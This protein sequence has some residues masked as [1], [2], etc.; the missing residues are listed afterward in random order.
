MAGVHTYKHDDTYVTLYAIDHSVGYGGRNRMDD[1]QLIQILV[2][3]Y[4]TATETIAK[5][6][7]PTW[8]TSRVLNSSGRVIDNLDVDGQCGPLTLAAI[9]AVQKSLAYWKGCTIDGRI[10][11]I[12]DGGR[13]HYDTGKVI[14]TINQFDP[15]QGKEVP[16][17]YMD[18]RFY[19]MYFLAALGRASPD[20][21]Q[22]NYGSDADYKKN[23]YGIS[24]WNN[25]SLP[26]PLKSS[27]I[28][29][30]IGATVTALGHWAK[31][32]S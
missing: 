12:P 5:E 1:V 26:E 19:T 7:G 10:D 4:I 13:S 6:Q 14:L 11:A 29:S 15:K 32:G 16:Y 8:D 21:T 31:S 3:R 18:D 20:E 17:H 27:L 28:R 9:L 24:Q 23:S 22:F 2:N 25:F 30:S